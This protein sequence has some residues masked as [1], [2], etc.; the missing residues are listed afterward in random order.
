LRAHQLAEA[1]CDFEWR[2]R[3]RE[4]PARRLDP[5]QAGVGSHVHDRLERLRELHRAPRGLAQARIFRVCRLQFRTRR[6]Q[7][8]PHALECRKERFRDFRPVDAAGDS[9]DQRRGFGHGSFERGDP[10]ACRSDG[11]PESREL[12][13]RI[14]RKQRGLASREFAAEELR[15]DLRHLVRL[16]EDHG[17]RARQQ[18]PEAFVLH[19]EVGQHQVMVDDH[20]VGGL[21]LAARSDHVAARVGGTGGAEAV[22]PRGRDGRARGIRVAKAADLGKVAGRGFARPATDAPEHALVRRRDAG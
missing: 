18:L 2:V 15:G 8:F 3:E 16:V 11:Q 6:I 1:R 17:F 5:S 22:L 9:R 12:R 14:A 4:R 19:R 7:C 13:E 21:R 20:D 10:L